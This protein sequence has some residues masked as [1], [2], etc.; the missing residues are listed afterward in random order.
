MTKEKTAKASSRGAA[1]G[2]VCLRL[3]PLASLIV[4][5]RWFRNLSGLTVRPAGSVWSRPS[6]TQ[7]SEPTG[8]EEGQQFKPLDADEL[9]I[10]RRN[11][12]L[13][14]LMRSGGGWVR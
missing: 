11:A 7:P 6:A 10:I 5:T 1:D 14:V 13:S 8:E 4:R 12:L 3:S 2:Q 9:R